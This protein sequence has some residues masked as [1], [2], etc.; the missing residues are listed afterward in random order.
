[1]RFKVRCLQESE[2]SILPRVVMVLV[3][4][5][6]TIGTM[7]AFSTPIAPM[8]EIFETFPCLDVLVNTLFATME[9]TRLIGDIHLL[10]NRRG[11]N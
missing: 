4:W 1:M 9:K 10:V 6:K 3:I 5:R 7:K 8:Y 2:P 11:S